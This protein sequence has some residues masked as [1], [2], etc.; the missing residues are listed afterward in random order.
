[1]TLKNYRA[2]M[3]RAL[4]AARRAFDEQ[5]NWSLLEVTDTEARFS[6][7]YGV[8]FVIGLHMADSNQYITVTDKGEFVRLACLL[9]G[10]QQWCDV[11]TLKDGILE[12]VRRMVRN[13]NRIY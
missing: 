2:D 12:A 13:A 6:W 3:E 1:M 4:E 11:A 8:K 5:Y 9:I 10:G 7:G